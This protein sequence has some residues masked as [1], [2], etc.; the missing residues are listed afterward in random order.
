MST[1]PLPLHWHTPDSWAQS[2]MEDVCQ[3]LDDHAHLERKAATNAMDLLNRWPQPAPPIGWVTT[4]ASI[5]RDET[6]H[7]FKVSKL[8][9]QRGRQLS[10]LHKSTYASGLREMIRMGSGQEELVDRL[11][12]SAL[13]ELRSCERF[14]ILG[15]LCPD[16]QLNKLYRA[17]WGSEHNHFQVFLKLARQIDKKRGKVEGRWQEMLAQEAELIQR[18]PRGPRLHSSG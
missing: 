8:L 13:I 11:L 5:A 18:E 16:P 7:L 17:L 14:E 2:A 10:R 12:V 6:D 4:L 9:A 1:E 15:R 3:L